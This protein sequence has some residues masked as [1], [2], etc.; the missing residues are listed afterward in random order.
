MNPLIRSL[1]LAALACLLATAA[2][3]QTRMESIYTDLASNRC[4]TIQVDRETGASVQRC[5]GVG[6]YKLLVLDDDSRQSITLIDPAG[7]KYPLNFWE[8]VTQGFSSVGQ[9][10]EWRVTR[11]RGKVV[12]VALIVRL[13]ASENPEDSSRITPYLTVTRIGAGKACVTHKVRAES[14][15]NEA[16]RRLADSSDSAAC[17]E[18]PR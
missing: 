1:E 6:G 13:N 9:K 2:H 5:T 7:H 10:A 18:A 14:P 16:A 3:S 12:P 4:R 11:R 8:V 17:L 15:A